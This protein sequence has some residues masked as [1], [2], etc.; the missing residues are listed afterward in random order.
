MSTATVISR[1]AATP[2]G[3]AAQSVAQVQAQAEALRMRALDAGHSL[4]LIAFTRGVCKAGRRQAAEAGG[5]PA[6]R[7]AWMAGA[8]R[9]LA[10]VV[11]EV[12]RN[13]IEGLDGLTR[14][15]AVVT[16]ALSA[17]RRQSQALLRVPAEHAEALAAATGELRALCPGMTSLRIVADPVLA[18]GTCVLS[19]DLG[20]IATS[21]EEQMDKL[22][23]AI[24]AA[25]G[26]L[27]RSRRL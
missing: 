19:S 15:R 25:P 1:A 5:S 27:H 2:V 4:Q 13:V 24:T 3:G 9:D 6:P 23:Q 12:V 7:Q 16:S 22:L 26:D 10:T 14:T 17:L 11:G 20:S 21:V 18:P 8:E